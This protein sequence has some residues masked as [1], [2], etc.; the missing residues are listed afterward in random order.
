[1]AP[2]RAY[3]VAFWIMMLLSFVFLAYSYA[4]TQTVDWFLIFVVIITVLIFRFA[5]TGFAWRKPSSIEIEKV[6]HIAFWGMNLTSL[7][8]LTLEYMA[9]NFFNYYVFYVFVAD[10]PTKFVLQFFSHK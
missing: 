7:V 1:M 9:M 8:V 4:I 10:L 6:E 5:W 3:G 2:E